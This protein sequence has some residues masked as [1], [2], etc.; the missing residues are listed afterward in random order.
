M[1]Y[2]GKYVQEWN[3]LEKKACFSD[4]WSVEDFSDA[5]R[6]FGMKVSVVEL[7]IEN[8][9]DVELP[10]IILKNGHY[11]VLYKIKKSKFYFADPRQGKISLSSKQL[12]EINRNKKTVIVLLIVP[13]PDFKNINF[14]TNNYF[15]SYRFVKSYFS[16]FYKH[17]TK[18]FCIILIVTT[19]QIA[20]PFIL[21][22][23]IDIGIQTDSWSFIRLLLI[24]SIALIISIVLGN[25]TQVFL[26][27]HIAN[28]IKVAMLEE[29][30]AKL[31]KLPLSFF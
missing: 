9:K 8:I 10:I 2:F 3:I 1:S 7:L 16:V 17:L 14:S 6:L 29:F 28:R 30:T 26:S 15:Q 18:L 5:G 19:A 31:L 23:L 21:R 27:T 13:A 11:S 4:G 20:L 24:A 22:A 12:E 25:F